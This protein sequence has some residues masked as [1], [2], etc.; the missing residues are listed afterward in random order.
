M[1]QSIIT[2][3]LLGI[4][5]QTLAASPMQ[6]CWNTYDKAK[7]GV[8]DPARLE[9]IEKQYDRCTSANIGKPDK[10]AR[11]QGVRIGMTEEEVLASSWGR[12]ERK[13][14]TTNKYGT[15]SQWVYGSGNYLYFENGVLTSIQN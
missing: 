14:N 2:F 15:R 3:L 12:P 13:N 9:Q 8:T 11:K 7:K 4:A 6:Q 1:R 10:S 5:G